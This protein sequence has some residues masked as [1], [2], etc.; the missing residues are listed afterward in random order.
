MNVIKGCW[1][2]KITLQGH[3]QYSKKEDIVCS[4]VSSVTEYTDM[5]ID[6]FDE[7][8]VTESRIESGDT[9]F[10]TISSDS[11]VQKIVENYIE[12]LESLHDEYPANI[13]V[14]VQD[15]WV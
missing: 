3:A 14:K 8:K 2:D 9:E 15:V 7:Y 5:L 11:K 6:S 13:I 4:A 1:I 12:F 10:S